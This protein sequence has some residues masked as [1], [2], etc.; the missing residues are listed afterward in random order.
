MRIITGPTAERGGMTTS[1]PGTTRYLAPELLDPLYFG[2]EHSNPSKE[3]DVYSFAVTAYEVFYSYLV[4]RI[5][6]KRFLP[7]HK[8]VLSGDVLLYG[9][10]PESVTAFNV[11]SGNRPPRPNN[12]TADH[13]LSDPTWEII[14]CCWDQNP[15]SR[16]PADLLHRT[17][18]GP[19]LEKYSLV[20]EGDEGELDVM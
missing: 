9:M 7:P 5:V 4:A 18:V 14:R 8:Q 19:E 6:D 3:S 20:I 1:K 15:Q 10:R 11:V 17:F 16:L 2:F 12:P 13:W